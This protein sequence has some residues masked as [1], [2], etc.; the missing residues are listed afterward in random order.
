MFY[1]LTVRPGGGVQIWC[2]LKNCGSSLMGNWKVS[3]S[4]ALH[5]YLCLDLSI[6][7]LAEPHSH[8]LFFSLEAHPCSNLISP[9]FFALWLNIS[10]SCVF[11]LWGSTALIAKQHDSS[12]AISGSKALP[13]FSRAL[14]VCLLLLWVRWDR[15][16]MEAAP[17]S[18]WPWLVM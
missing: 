15:W 14:C 8:D 17:S 1:C 9:F 5:P 3:R 2:S 13:N 10:H 11:L 18:F 7:A 16:V 6:R 4:L 12:S